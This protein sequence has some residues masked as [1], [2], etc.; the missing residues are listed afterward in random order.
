M[1]IEH[2][3]NAARLPISG[4]E[5]GWILET[6]IAMNRAMAGMNGHIVRRYRMYERR[7]GDDV[8]PAWPSDARVYDPSRA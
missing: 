2:F 8:T 1:F 3:D 4:G 7:F 6:N 5:M